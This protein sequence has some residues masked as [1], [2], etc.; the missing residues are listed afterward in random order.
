MSDVTTAPRAGELAAL[1]G[2][3]LCH[4]L[5]SPLGAIG[6]GVELLEMSP[7]FP[8]IGNSPEIRLIAEAV[9]SAR[10]RIQAFRMAFGTAQ[11]DQRV[12]RAELQKLVDGISAQG[13]LRVQLDAE[14]DFAR[15][16][17]RMV[18]LGLLCLETVMPWGGRVLVLRNAPGWRLIAECD[19]ARLD[20]DLWAWLS[21]GQG[22][23]AA[24]SE[25]QFPLLAEL[26]RTENR[27]LVAEF[28]QSGGEIAF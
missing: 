16:Q 3:R 4:D 5:V 24:P 13:R 27:R 1:L 9:A 26:A 11:E 22:R 25:V 12:P 8:D 10:N 7:D 14:G 21:V 17:V 6:N 2:S 23:E 19:R 18:M 28:D 15:P 20:A